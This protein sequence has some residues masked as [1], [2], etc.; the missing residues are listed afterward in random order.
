MG[1]SGGGSNI[2]KSHT[3]NGLTVQDGGALDF[4]DITQSQSSAGMVFFSD[5]THLQQLAYPGSPA[6]ETLTAVAASTSPSWVAS[7]AG[8][9]E[10][11]VVPLVEAS[12]G[13]RKDVPRFGVEVLAND[14]SIGKTL[15]SV[16][17]YLQDGGA[18]GD[19]DARV[20]N[21]GGTLQ[22]TST[23]TKAWNTLPGVGFEKVTFDISHT[24]VA[25]D[26]IVIAGG[27]T[28]LGAEV[29]VNHSPSSEEALSQTYPTLYNVDFQACVEYNSATSTWNY[30][31]SLTSCIKWCYTTS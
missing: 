18:S 12:N 26:R 4:N 10:T 27:T 6:G 20:Y 19:G 1:F 5:G 17:F 22:A 23:N 29:T 15:T 31:A 21:S 25:G 8:A 14:L 2:L 9:A 28:G 7:A 13:L 30:Q 11:C 24:V 16:S 3:H